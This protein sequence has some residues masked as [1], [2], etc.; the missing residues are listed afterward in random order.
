MPAEK[1]TSAD[2]PAVESPGV[3]SDPDLKNC[4]LGCN[5]FRLAT[6]DATGGL[7]WAS[8]AGPIIAANIFLS[9]A[10]ITL[11]EREIGCDFDDDDKDCDEKVYGFS[12]AS[13]VPLIATLSGL[14]TAFFLPI[15]GAI[16]DYTPRRRQLFLI[17]VSTQVV[18]Q[19]VQIYTVEST[20][21]PMSILQGV[22]GFFYQ[23]SLV[24]GYSYLPEVSAQVGEKTMNWYS[25]LYYIAQFGNQAAFFI[26]M[27]AVSIFLI[28]D[29]VNLAQFSQGVDVI[30]NGI[31]WFVA[32]YYYT[33]KD[34]RR[35]L[36]EG[37]NIASAGFK[38]VARTACGISKHYPKTIGRFFLGILFSES[39]VN[40]FTTV[41]VAYFNVTLDMGSAEIGICFVIVMVMTIP[42]SLFS[43]WLAN[44]KNALVSFKINIVTFIIIN[45]GLFF[46]LSDKSRAVMAYPASSLWG[47]VIGWHYSTEKALY[48]QIIPAG[49]ESELAGFFL[50]CGA[51]LV[52]IPPLIFTIMI[53]ADVPLHW[54]GI[55]LNAYFLIGL[56]FYQSMPSWDKIIEDAKGENRMLPPPDSKKSEKDFKD[57]NA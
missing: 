8:G 37:E 12:P 18:I 6:D 26:I 15:I 13:L 41:A 23:I 40:A 11:A 7:Y 38:Q 4:P 30:Y 39:A 50:Y 16:V 32:Y 46:L 35:E 28:E 49:Q 20:W 29:D 55:S 5:K 51:V 57:D 22:T 54:G 53:E 42:G 34:K 21:F 31:L 9:S 36:P 45:F 2:K 24:A 3:D 17:G 25:S 52:W 19:A 10:F 48:S 33:E 56:C 1:E 44:K 43:S 14:L 27:V 47:I